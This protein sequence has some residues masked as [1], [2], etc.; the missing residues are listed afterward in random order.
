MKENPDK[1]VEISKD[2]REIKSSKV[3]THEADFDKIKNLFAI[4]LADIKKQLKE[5]KC[6]NSIVNTEI[7]KELFAEVEEKKPKTIEDISQIVVN[8][9]NQATHL[10]DEHSELYRQTLEQIMMAVG[11]Q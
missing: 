11:N 3:S 8:M 10:D 6:P 4:I 5:M 1:K 7:F 9:V 2:I